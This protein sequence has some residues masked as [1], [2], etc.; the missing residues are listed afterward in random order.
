MSTSREVHLTFTNIHA[1][2]KKE[3]MPMGAK[4][5]FTMGNYHCNPQMTDVINLKFEFEK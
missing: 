2:H 5:A 4:N 1:N 3:E